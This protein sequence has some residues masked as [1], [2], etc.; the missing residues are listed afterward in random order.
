MVCD[1]QVTCV[2]EIGVLLASCFVD[3]AVKRIETCCV[4]TVMGICDDLD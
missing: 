1:V 2:Q 4:E 3:C